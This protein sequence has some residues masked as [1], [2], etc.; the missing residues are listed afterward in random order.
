MNTSDI[1]TDPI[2]SLKRKGTAED[3]YI[4]IE[5][6]HTVHLNR[7][8]LTEIP[9]K[10][11]GVSVYYFHHLTNRKTPLY[12]ISE[13][14]V[15]DSQFHVDYTNGH[16]QFSDKNN[17]KSFYFSY[18]GA[19]SKYLSD[20]RVYTQQE[21][22]R[23]TETLRHFINKSRETFNTIR[24]QKTSIDNM[25]KEMKDET[26]LTKLETQRSVKARSDLESFAENSLLIYKPAVKT[27]QELLAKYP[28][29]SIG[30]AVEVENAKAVYRWDSH[31]WVKI[32]VSHIIDGFSVIS[33]STPPLNVNHLWLQVGA[34]N[35][36]TSYRVKKSITPPLINQLWLDI[37]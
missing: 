5:E 24:E 4:H 22:G 12:E 19:G 37:R 18:K 14:L 36:A 28:R 23:P 35:Q 17:S 8:S 29:P 33:H 1:Y 30:W 7:V 15:N 32:G 11:E 31:E 20:A 10:L 9:A 34:S 13:G 27:Y 2:L 26:A 6:Q 21:N 16:I 3:P 25:I